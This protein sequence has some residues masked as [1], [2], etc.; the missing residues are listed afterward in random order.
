MSVVVQLKPERDASV[1][2]QHPWIF[3]GAVAKI[4]GHAEKGAIARIESSAGELLGTGYLSQEGSIAVKMLT[5]DETEIDSRFWLNRIGRAIELREQLGL[6]SSPATDSFRLVHAEGDGCAGLVIDLYGRT[7]VLQAQSEGIRRLRADI[8]AALKQLL[9]HRLDRI[10]D[11]SASA[12]AR[13]SSKQSPN[14]VED[15]DGEGGVPDRSRFILGEPG[16][17][18]I[19][20]NGNRFI[21]DYEQGQKTGFF[22]DQ[23]ENRALLGRYARGKRVLNAFCYSGGFSIY[24]L[25]GGATHVCSIDSSK[26]AIELLEQ[27]VRVNSHA[28]THEAVTADFLAYMSTLDS[29]Y[30][31]LV[32]DPPAF[33]KH[34]E[35]ISSGLKGYR[36]INQRAIE[37]LPRGGLLFTFSCSQL[38]TLEQFQGTITDALLRAGRSA[39]VLHVL[40]QSPCHPVALTHPEGRYLKGLVLR[41]D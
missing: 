35:A 22:L 8:G 10:Y 11:K 13:E 19:S 2:R 6:F 40:Q 33:A 23:R 9:A 29:S 17:V 38:V 3:S 20:E 24:A 18:E 7:A 15:T 32:L 39:T 1:R 36:S 28:G 4:R 37:V 27:N 34:R 31:I 25:T 12:H 16:A 14:K 5:F 26:K 21:V 30:D 41:I